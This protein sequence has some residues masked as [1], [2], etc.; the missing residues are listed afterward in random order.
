MI[1]GAP[2][3]G[4]V[5]ALVDV[6]DP[7]FA[8]GMVGQ[9][10]ALDPGPTAG[11][12]DVVSPVAGVLQSVRPHAF[13][14]R[15]G[16]WDVLV[17]LGLDTVTSPGLF[18]LHRGQGDLCAAGDLVVT[19]RPA[20]AAAAGLP[21]VCPVV[22]LQSSADRVHPLAGPGTRLGPGDPLLE[23]LATR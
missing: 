19:W 2:L 23:T 3:A 4:T 12:V 21:T 6:P 8:T 5:V 22:V 14:V 10:L 18:T 11:D 17:H 1:V 15:A 20:D 9:G 13:V 16:E 7:V